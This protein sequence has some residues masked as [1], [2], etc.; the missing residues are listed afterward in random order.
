MDPDQLKLLSLISCLHSTGPT[1]STVKRKLYEDG[2][3]PASSDGAKKVVKKATANVTMA[4]AGTPTVISV[5]PA[6][7][8]VTSGLQGSPSNQ[9]SVKKQKTAGKE[10]KLHTH[11]SH[12]HTHTHTRQSE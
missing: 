10:R 2:A 1:K 4:T 11:T 6:Q 5:P 3:L 8:V 7:V 12:T 9:P